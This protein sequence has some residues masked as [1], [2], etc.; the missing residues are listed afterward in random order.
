MCSLC[1]TDE[2]V[3]SATTTADNYSESQGMNISPCQP[4][5]QC[6]A[7]DSILSLS[8]VLE[9][10]HEIENMPIPVLLG[11]KE[12]DLGRLYDEV[13]ALGGYEKCADT[14]M[15]SVISTNLGFGEN[16]GPGLKLLYVKCFDKSPMLD[17]SQSSP[18]VCV[19]LC[20]TKSGEESSTGIVESD[21]A[22][23][24]GSISS[25]SHGNSHQSNGDI[26]AKRRR[27]YYCSEEHASGSSVS[28]SRVPTS[29]EIDTFTEAIEWLKQIALNPGDPKQ[30]QGVHGSK[31]NEAWV[32]NCLSVAY[33][34]RAILWGRK[35]M[36]YLGSSLVS[37]LLL[38][39]HSD[40]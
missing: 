10:C 30:G 39:W 16:C 17:S 7:N 26:P 1:T 31:K 15:W 40:V 8:S 29:K 9:S 14:A 36:I 34:I 21:H 28:E 18:L 6:A 38:S 19:D 32:K 37:S 27:V 20:S 5:R 23:S 2:E 25:D 3:Q 24:G 12:V 22:G 11:G 33:K 35:E 4:L 13:M